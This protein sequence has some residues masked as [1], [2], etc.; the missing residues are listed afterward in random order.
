MK[1]AKTTTATMRPAEKCWS[2]RPPFPRSD[3][4]VDRLDVDDEIPHADDAHA[5][6]CG[7]RT[8]RPLRL[9]DL[10]VDEDRP[11]RL[12]R[13]LHDPDLPAQALDTGLQRRVAG[14]DGE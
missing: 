8:R 6:P 12:E 3:F 4:R 1:N 5:G 11:F 9:P 14:L 2:M 13:M 7:K 10:A